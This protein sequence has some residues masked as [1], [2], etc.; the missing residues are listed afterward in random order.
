MTAKRPKTYNSWYKIII[1]IG[2]LSIS[3]YYIYYRIFKTLPLEL[4]PVDIV[5]ALLI[6]IVEILEAFEFFIYF[7]NNLLYKKKSPKTPR[8]DEKKLGEVD[9]FIATL[10]EEDELLEGTLKACKRLNYPNKVHVYLCDD[11]EREHLKDLAEKYGANYLGRTTHLCA[12]AGNYNYA[13]KHSSSPYIAIFDADMR[14]KKNFLLETMPF[15]VKRKKLGFVQTPQSFRNPDIFQARFSKKMP[16]E[17]D[18]FYKYIQLARNNVNSTILCGTNCVIS[19][20]ALKEAGG[21][22]QASIAEDVATGMIIESKGYR[23]IAISKELAYGETIDSYSA[24]LKQRSRWGRGCIQTAK[25]YDILRLKGLNLRQKLDYIVAINYWY[26][27]FRRLLF[28]TLPLLFVFFN[29]IAIEADLKVFI[30]L[31]FAQYLLKRFIIDALERNHRSATWS[32]IYE[33]IQAPYLAVVTIKEFLGF[34]NKK[35][36]VTPKNRP[37]KHSTLDYIMLAI[38]F[39]LLLISG[40]ALALAIYKSQLENFEIYAIPIIWI[41]VNLCYLLA[42]VTF[43]L[44]DSTR[45]NY[46]VK[47]KKRYGLG[48]FISIIWRKK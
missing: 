2:I 15:F 27:G 33:L 26:F 35:F 21:F 18:Y 23:G 13:L 34:S 28:M 8:V 42:A 3:T 9:I 17:Q 32:K 14:P 19:R 29:I 22:S 4:R 40:A 37:N 44:R 20:Q 43:D 31:F 11:G 16:C 46:D 24:F 45:T 48:S 1:Y 25:A 36:V 30:P 39:I 47:A 12:K 7:R 6:L 5:F 38:H 10:N 41:F